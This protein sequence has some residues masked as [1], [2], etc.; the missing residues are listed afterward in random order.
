[1]K[2][3]FDNLNLD[4]FHNYEIYGDLIV[5]NLGSMMNAKKKNWN[6]ELISQSKSI[7]EADEKLYQEFKNLLG[8]YGINLPDYDEIHGK[9]IMELKVETPYF[10]D[11]ELNIRNFAK[12]YPINEIYKKMEDAIAIEKSNSSGGNKRK[13]LTKRR[14]PTKRKIHIKRRPTKRR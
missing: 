9:K 6:T 2:L 13:R 11:L 10:S 1:M 7:K 3:S 5:L 12:K 14:R 4:K 8:N